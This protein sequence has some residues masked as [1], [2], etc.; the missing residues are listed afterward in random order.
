M[1]RSPIIPGA[2]GTTDATKTGT[3]RRMWLVAEC[4]NVPA[5]Y[6]VMRACE[7]GAESR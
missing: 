1:G 4:E 2:A 7:C 5:I 3:S 6:P